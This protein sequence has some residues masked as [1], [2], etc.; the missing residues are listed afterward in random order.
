MFSFLCYLI[1]ILSTFYMLGMLNTDD[2]DD[3]DETK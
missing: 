2:Y 3:Y 1:L